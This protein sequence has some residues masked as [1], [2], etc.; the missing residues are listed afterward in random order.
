MFMM[1]SGDTRDALA[2]A[3]K[4]GVEITSS[5]EWVDEAA[6]KATLK[7]QLTGME[8]VLK[9]QNAIRVIPVLDVTDS[10]SCCDTPDH[11]QAVLMHPVT[12]FE[13][14]TQI[15]EQQILPTLPDREQYT[16]M[17]QEGVEHLYLPLPA[18]VDPT[19]KARLICVSNAN[20][21]TL[22]FTDPRGWQIVYVTEDQ[23][24]LAGVEAKNVSKL[25][26]TARTEEGGRFPIGLMRK[27]E[28]RTALLYRRGKI[29]AYGCLK[30][31]MERLLEEYETLLGMIF[32]QKGA[33]VC[34]VAFASGYAVG[35]W[36][37]QPD[38]ALDFIR[39]QEYL[40]QKPE[41]LDPLSGTNHEA[42][43]QGAIQAR[44][45]VD[46]EEKVFVF[47]L[48]D[49]ETNVGYAHDA[50][51]NADYQQLD[52]H[53]HR[54]PEENASMNHQF[55]L[56]AQ[57]EAQV[58]Q[59]DTVVYSMGYG[60][61]S[62]MNGEVR[63]LLQNL[64]SADGLFMDSSQKEFDSL[65]KMFS[66]AF[67]DVLQK[68]SQVQVSTYISEYW[69]VDTSR[70]VPDSQIDT[71]QMTNQ[72]GEEDHIA[73][74]T[75]PIL[76]TLGREDSESIEIP[77]Q[78]REAYRSVAVTTEYATNQDFPLRKDREREG[79]YVE[80]IRPDQTQAAAYAPTPRLIVRPQG[81]SFTVRK[82]AG[83]KVV[84]AGDAVRYEITVTNTGNALLRELLVEDCFEDEQIT[85]YFLPHRGCTAGENGTILIDEIAPGE[86]V[87][88]ALQALIPETYTGTLENR[89]V[90][91]GKNP[92]DPE[93]ELVEE[94]LEHIEVTE[95][96]ADF[97]V[98]K[99]ADKKIVSPGEKIIYTIRIQNT[100][101]RT[102]HS[103]LTT[104][105]FKQEGIKVRFLPQK[106]ITLSEDTSKVTIDEIRVGEEKNIQAELLVPEDY[107]GDTIVN[108][109]V[110]EGAKLSQSANVSV[111]VRPRV[112]QRAL[113]NAATASPTVSVPAVPTAS[114]TVSVTAIP[115][116]SIA[117]VPQTPTA[118]AAKIA[119]SVVT[120]DTRNLLFWICLCA[121]LGAGIGIGV[122]VIKKRKF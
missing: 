96:K 122:L 51:G 69:D 95:K 44:A 5:A 85:G 79:S 101:E 25:A 57:Q 20:T 117:A 47:F 38:E 40:V 112:M 36:T 94:A 14:Y 78:L 15:W 86:T 102:L 63:E 105:K 108:T 87:S 120:G 3:D 66:T 33:M 103:I 8:D 37:D 114:P 48:T 65:G 110:V 30:S 72:Q 62:E 116:V 97:K 111:Q 107:T 9:Y 12:S 49:G 35:S 21:D 27:L 67:R 22:P 89:V 99:T 74:I 71:V 113:D 18:S 39:K 68:A 92:A 50:E 19:A 109:V 88:L 83:Q 13:H 73:K 90:V 118:Y 93:Q 28:E 6:G 100:G 121:C 54:Q 70:A 119:K 23:S 76:N 1:L 91:R 59:A 53:S 84:S 4:T 81:A 43:I 7:L 11:L 10:M 60:Y 115:T 77:L 64:A 55:S 80:Y 32:E 61:G 45:S 58:L 16:A 56:W 82:T 106:G 98:E 75:F 24:L 41:E 104:D 2:A 42:G 46:A 52:V 29:A 34:P 31:R 26:H 17:G